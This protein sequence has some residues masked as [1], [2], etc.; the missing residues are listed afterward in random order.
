M[1][2]PRNDQK[3]AELSSPLTSKERGELEE[4]HRGWINNMMVA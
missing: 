2:P 1:Q 4:Q 3:L